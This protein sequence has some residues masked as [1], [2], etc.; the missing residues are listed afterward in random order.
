MKI[1]LEIEMDDSADTVAVARRFSNVASYAAGFIG[2]CM[3]KAG[4]VEVHETGLFGDVFRDAT[5][6]KITIDRSE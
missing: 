2:S 5:S 6:V 3:V 4:R 1:N